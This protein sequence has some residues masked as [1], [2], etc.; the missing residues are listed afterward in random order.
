MIMKPIVVLL[1]LSENPQRGGV[2]IGGFTRFGP[3]GP[4]VLNSKFF[5]S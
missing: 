1:V 4:E 5:N 2:H 3:R